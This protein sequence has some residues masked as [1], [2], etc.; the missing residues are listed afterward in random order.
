MTSEPTRAGDSARSGS[1]VRVLSKGLKVLR[2]LNER[3]E[4]SAMDLSKLTGIPRPTIY[5][6][7]NTLIADGY[8]TVTPSTRRY[9][10]T[11]RVLTLSQGYRSQS[12]IIDASQDVLAALQKEIV[13]PSDIATYHDGGMVIRAT[14]NNISPVSIV[15]ERAGASLSVL[16]SSLG[17][18]FLAFVDDVSRDVILDVLSAEES[19]DAGLAG[20]R[21]AVI[22]M[23][24]GV[25]KAGHAERIGG[26]A[27]RTF[28]FGVPVLREGRCEAAMNIICFPSAISLEKARQDL[29]PRLKQ[30][31]EDVG[32][33][34]EAMS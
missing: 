19:Q 6:L 18:A 9:R 31:A 30:A 25:Q 15:P 17:Q 2:A 32:R 22:A 13:W 5:R 28:S 24:K 7:L 11:D 1:L 27:P 4:L 8:V 26:I 29:L 20:D 34:L 21:E 33:R 14:T 16:G 23:L 3:Y 10:A 12:K